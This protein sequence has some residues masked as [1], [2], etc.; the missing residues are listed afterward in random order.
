MSTKFYFQSVAIK[1]FRSFHQL[2]LSRLKRINI[3]GGYNGVGKTALLETLFF[4][5]DRRDPTALIKPLSWRRIVEGGGTIDPAQF[6][7]DPQ[8]DEAEVE[9]VHRGGKTKIEL[10][11]ELPPPNVSVSIASGLRPAG[12]GTADTSQK[13]MSIKSYDRAGAL[14]ESAFL[15]PASNGAIGNIS[16]SSELPLPTA[17]ILSIATRGQA[18]ETST[19]LSALVKQRKIEELLT[20]LRALVPDLKGIQ[21]LQEGAAPQIYAEIGNDFLPVQYLGDGFQNLFQT[22]LGVMNATDGVLLL[23]EIDAALHYS[24]IA[25]IWAIIAKMA[26]VYNC[27]IFATT[28]SRECINSAAAGIKHAGRSADFQYLRIEKRNNEHFSVPY[29]MDEVENAEMSDIEIR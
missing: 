17:Q 5:L 20:A 13:G 7:R 6:F 8:A 14:L 19:R 26:D 27:Q 3:I 2:K 16:K 25:E 10:K 22:L 29:D 4:F 28:H 21:T 15:L 11:R 23:D 1:N 12:F 9:C 24:K 18:Q